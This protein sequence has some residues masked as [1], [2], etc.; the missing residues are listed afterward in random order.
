MDNAS[1]VTALKLR[2]IP[3]RVSMVFFKLKR[4]VVYSGPDPPQ[5]RLKLWLYLRQINELKL[6]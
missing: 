3:S 5:S 4:A 2:R 6:N 1:V